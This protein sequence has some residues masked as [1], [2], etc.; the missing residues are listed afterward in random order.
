MTLPEVGAESEDGEGDVDY[1]FTLANE[2]TFLAW[3][4]TA[5]GLLAGGVAVH[6]LVQPLR[7][8]GFAGVIAGSCL[9][10]ALAV[11]IG[12]YRHWRR[13]NIVM[14]TGGSLPGTIL[15][16]VLSV[17]VALVAVLACVAVLLS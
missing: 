5:L 6:T 1:R 10:M 7:L 8:A 3:I 15:V 2:R 17:G 9:I 12:A 16:P 11:A 13:V 4:R 14:R